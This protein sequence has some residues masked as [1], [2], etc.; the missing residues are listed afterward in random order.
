[1]TILLAVFL[2]SILSASALAYDFPNL[3]YRSCYDGDTC[4]FD[5][6][7]VHPFFGE[8]IPVRLAGIDTPEKEGNAKK[9]K[10]RQS[11]PGTE[12]EL[13]SARHRPSSSRMFSVENIFGLWLRW[14]PMGSMCP[15]F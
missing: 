5:I 14:G 12:L 15:R 13:S 6:P 8:N 11:K 1:M 7:N 9:R 10:T 3:T 2:L 4:R